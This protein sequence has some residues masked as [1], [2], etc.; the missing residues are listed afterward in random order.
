M[1]SSISGWFSFF[2]SEVGRLVTNLQCL[3]SV[4]CCWK[5]TNVDKNVA[6][7]CCWKVTNVNKNVASVGVRSS[8]IN[9][10]L[11]VWCAAEQLPTPT[12]MCERLCDG[13]RPTHSY[14]FLP[15][16]QSPSHTD[17]LCWNMHRQTKNT[18]IFFF[19]NDI[20][21]QQ[22]QTHFQA[23]PLNFLHSGRGIKR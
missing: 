10:Q 5:V 7:M 22:V 6:Y 15:P 21:S 18:H 12:R 17:S 19:L 8:I 3:A 11:S 14:P 4:M 1:S 2:V 20:L 9:H 23:C 16:L 13:W